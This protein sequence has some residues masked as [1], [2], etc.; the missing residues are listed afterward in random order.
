MW[1]ARGIGRVGSTGRISGALV[2]RASTYCRDVSEIS[3][4]VIEVS[5][6]F[7]I[8][9]T[10]GV[11]LLLLLWLRVSETESAEGRSLTSL[12]ICEAATFT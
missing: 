12:A 4:Y 6:G 9:G 8:R 10:S 7:P 3:G 2:V 5:S 1:W 11:R